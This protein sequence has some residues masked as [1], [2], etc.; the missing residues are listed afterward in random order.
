[1]MIDAYSTFMQLENGRK[2]LGKN[3]ASLPVIQTTRNSQVKQQTR[4]A[5]DDLGMPNF[6]RYQCASLSL[7]EAQADHLL[8]RGDGS[9]E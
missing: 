7:D 3:V 4:T 8:C 6:T 2:P 1:M 9:L 5:N